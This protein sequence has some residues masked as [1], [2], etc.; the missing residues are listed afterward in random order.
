MQFGF[1]PGKSTTDAIFLVRQLQ[2][3]YLA[4]DKPLYMA[5]VDLEKAFDRIPRS[6]IWWALR[7]LGIDEWLVS[8]V[9]A[10]Y[11]DSSSR[12]R[13][14]HEYSEEFRIR[15]GV[16]QGSALSPLLFIIVL[17]AI[18]EEFRTGCPWELL[19]ADD[20]AL[21][22]ETL[23]ELER[24]FQSWKQGLESKGLRVNLAKTKVLVSRKAGKPVVPSGKW[25]CAVC[26]S[27]VGSNSIRCSQCKH[28][29]HKRCTNIRGRLTENVGFVCGRCAGTIASDSVQGTEPIPCE[30]GSLGVVD[31]F[32]YLGD[33][34]SSGGGCSESVAGRI[35]IGWAKFREL[36]PLLTA[37][38]LS[39][40][41]KGRL[42][43]ACVRTA[44]L[45]GSEAWAVTAD[46]MRRLERN[47]GC[48]LRWICSVRM[49][50]QQSVSSLRERLCIR[51]IGCSVQERRLRW[52]GHVMRMNDSS[53]VKK[54]QSL[55]VAGTRGRGRPRKTW[56]EVVKSDLKALG[57]TSDMTNDRELWRI[58]VL[59]RTRRA[60]LTSTP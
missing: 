22:A 11:R 57:L 55:D 7:K 27:G 48:M 56:I 45:H 23:P 34:I 14:G 51:G 26:R 20:L 4:K 10:M 16:H 41:V 38:G 6:L 49:Y 32:S 33:K 8:A 19:Y 3:K 35:R 42:Y 43:D 44:M 47:E 5:F 37:K 25:P 29:T 36:L 53:S 31:S 58:A 21:I 59:E 50:D 15:V 18:T 52:Y 46:D 24:K 60:K 12:V 9:R 28:W 2:E 54:C 13:I 39:L 17:Q 30:G 1:V 40:R